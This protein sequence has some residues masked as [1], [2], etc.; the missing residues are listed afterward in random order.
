MALNY[1]LDDIKTRKEN[2]VKLLN[3][4]T[5]KYR[6]LYSQIAVIA[7]PTEEQISSFTKKRKWLEMEADSIHS[8]L[9]F[10]EELQTYAEQEEAAKRK[11]EEEAKKAE[12]AANAGTSTEEPAEETTE[13]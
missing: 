8:Q 7:D 6:T 13:E 3:T 2:A 9:S 5:D 11:A 4:H 1:T 12:E 10:I